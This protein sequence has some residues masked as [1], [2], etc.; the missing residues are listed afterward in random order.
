MMKTVIIE[1][2]WPAAQALQKLIKET[3]PS[4]EVLTV[5]QT[6]AD[7]VE[8]FQAHGMPDLLFADIHLADGSSFAIFEQVNI[9]CP[10]IFT[11][12]Y[13]EYALKAFEVNSID[14]LLK[15]INKQDLLRAFAKLRT[16]TPSAPDAGQLLARLLRQIDADK[17]EYKSYF[18]V[19]EKDKLMPLAVDSIAYFYIDEKTVKVVTMGGKVSSLSQNLDQLTEQLDPKLFFRANRQFIIAHQA[20]KEISFWFGNKLWVALKQ[21]T[22]EKIIIS[23]ARVPEFKAWFSL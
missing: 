7:S 17:K 13:D 8:W 12:A 6:I 3:D 16:L 15:P 18:L 4:I 19:P 23:K 22:P 14:Y 2:E 10:V 11:T 1:D 5:L 21:E 9:T 20:V